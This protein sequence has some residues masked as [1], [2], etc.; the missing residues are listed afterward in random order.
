MGSYV[1]PGIWAEMLRD[2]KFFRA[3]GAKESPWKPVGPAEAVVMVSENSYVGEHTPRIQPPADRK[4]CGISQD[5]LGLIKG[6]EY[7]GRI[8]IAGS[9]E[10]APVEVSLVWGQERD[11][12]ATITIPTITGDF[13]KVPLSF[14]AQKSTDN[15]RLEIVGLGSGTFRI[16]TVSLMPHDNISGLRADVLKLLKELDSPIYRWPGGNFVS[17]YDWRDGIGDRDKRPPRKNLMTNVDNLDVSAAWTSDRKALT[18]GVV[19]PTEQK[20]E[21]AMDLKGARLTG[22]RRLWTIAH[23]HPMAY[24]EPGK[25]PQVV[26]DERPVKNVTD[27]LVS[28]PLSISLYELPT[29]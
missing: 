16:G 14:K 22:E 5:G 24:S 23:S 26:I 6:K 9:P 8:V 29:R 13:V 25:P 3:V 15:G 19:N 10:A 1:Y 21:L 7:T 28:P 12:R 11:E 17:G 20:Y 2:R 27:T 18:I 4:R